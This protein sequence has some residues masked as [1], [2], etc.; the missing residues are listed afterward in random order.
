MLIP[1]WPTSE[2]AG[3]GLRQAL[4]AGA[5][6]CGLAWTLVPVV[7]ALALH[8]DVLD[9]PEAR[10]VHAHATPRLGGLAVMLA[11]IVTTVACLLGNPAGLQTVIPHL[12]LATMLLAVGA[13]DDV[14]GMPASAKLA[15]TGLAAV[16]AAN[17]GLRIETIALPW[18][19]VISTG[20]FAVP[21]TVLWIVAV[22]HAV[23]LIDG[24]DGL[25]GSVTL[26]AACAA[27]FTRMASDRF[28]PAL[29]AMALA[30]AVLGFLRWNWTPARIFL[31]DAGSL[32]I[33]GLLAVLALVPIDRAGSMVRVLDVT[34][35]LM[36]AYPITDTTLAVMRRWLRGVGLSVADRGHIH[37]RLLD[38]GLPQ[39]RP[40][41]WLATW[42]AAAA[43]V[44]LAIRHTADRDLR[45]TFLALGCTLLLGALVG[46]RHLGVRE[47]EALAYAMTS[48]RRSG[49]RV[50][51]EHIHTT[52][53]ADQVKRAQSL[54]EVD[55]ALNE[56][57]RRVGLL[58]AELT[59]SSA[60]RRLTEAEIS[61]EER[62]AVWS[63]D[64]PLTSLPGT[65]EDP[66][67]LRLY[68]AA[69]GVVRPHTAAR[70]AE[71]L[72][73]ALTAWLT[74]PRQRE[75][76]ERRPAGR[77]ARR[78]PETNPEAATNRDAQQLT[79]A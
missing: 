3:A 16:V 4:A 18:G 6:A 62:V 69:D 70:A 60:R 68:G 30:G 54:D 71:A 28:V 50:I 34:S 59:R 5:I 27:A 67:V 57:G 25:A 63:L 53:S 78:G 66:I 37:H 35:L 43:A 46:L 21:I 55:A 56:C 77:R 26:V 22:C 79:G 20:I 29:L 38:A 64:W 73:P 15:F 48:M 61:P 47:I 23:N 76:L 51:Q 74:L 33:G 72:L 40:T 2:P 9:Q 19:D 8:F 39:P 14:R 36:L 42:S 7:R 45:L 10:R 58:G 12:A 1:A 75:L 31:G 65:P 11:V 13:A 49:R 52:D 44:G 24:L 17:L 41:I 32:G